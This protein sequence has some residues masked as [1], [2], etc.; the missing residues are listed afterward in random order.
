L[1]ASVLPLVFMSCQQFYGLNTAGLRD[2]EL[3][4]I[5]ETMYR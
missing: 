1:G 2:F 5:P 3:A 4:R